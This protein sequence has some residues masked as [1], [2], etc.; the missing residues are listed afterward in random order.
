MAE[1]I[2]ESRKAVRSDVD[3]RDERIWTGRPMGEAALCIYVD[4]TLDRPSSSGTDGSSEPQTTHYPNG[5][6]P[7]DSQTQQLAQPAG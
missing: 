7:P 6:Q 3:K 5:P 2:N 4:F 1:K